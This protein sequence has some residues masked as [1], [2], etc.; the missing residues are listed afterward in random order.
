MIADARLP[1]TPGE[2]I[3]LSLA[4]FYALT[5][6]QLTTLW[7]KRSSATFVQ[8]RLLALTRAGYLTRSFLPRQQAAGSGAYLYLLGPQGRKHLHLIGAQG[9]ARSHHKTPSGSAFLLHLVKVNDALISAL[10]LPDA[11]LVKWWHDK[12]IPRRKDD[13]APDGFLHFQAGGEIGI[14][15]EI[16]RGS[17]QKPSW[18]EKVEAYLD[19][20]RGRFRETFGVKSLTVAVF[21]PDDARSIQLAAWTMQALQAAGKPNWASMFLFSSVD[22][23]I[24][25]PAEVWIGRAWR[26]VDGEVGKSLIDYESTNT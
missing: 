24:A 15:L 18:Q 5:A 6:T 8:E 16:D 25:S 2:K 3:L 21:C 11:Q 14:A 17:M 7:Y 26:Q 19:F 9:G 13:P 12:A 4:D 10:K 20:G 1:G 23:A 22:P